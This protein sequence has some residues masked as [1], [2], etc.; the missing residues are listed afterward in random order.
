MS[1]SSENYTSGEKQ[2]HRFEE[3]SK[4]EEQA[5]NAIKR[6]FF[7]KI[8]NENMLVWYINFEKCF[9]IKYITYSYY[10]N[11]PTEIRFL[12]I[13]LYKISKNKQTTSGTKYN[14]KIRTRSGTF[15]G[16]H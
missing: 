5:I 10:I 13:K 2:S 1:S 3:L 16:Q 4:N 15:R 11:I 9:E 12:Q 6:S 8:G 14:K 7:S